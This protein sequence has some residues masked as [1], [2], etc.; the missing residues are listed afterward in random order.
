MHE[1]PCQA[2]GIYTSL[3]NSLLY[4]V[5]ERSHGFIRT[6]QRIPERSEQD[7]LEYCVSTSVLKS[8]AA[9]KLVLTR[10]AAG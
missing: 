3:A 7:G 1:S 2:F 8:K 10:T 9:K 5:S 6:G 4:R